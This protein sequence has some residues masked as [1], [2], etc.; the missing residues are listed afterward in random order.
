MTTDRR[1]RTVEE[2]VAFFDEWAV[3]YDDEN[4]G[5]LI[6]TAASLVVDHAAPGPYDTVVDLG[7]GTGAVALA[8]AD[9]AGTVV[10]RDVSEGMLARAREKAAERGVENVEF[11]AGSFREPNVDD[12][13]VVVSNFALHHLGGA[14]QCDAI[15]AIAEL[16]PRKLVTGHCMFF[17]DTDPAEPVYSR[18]TIYPSTV[19]RLVDALTDAGFAV[20][21]VEKIHDQVGVLVGERLDQS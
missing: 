19:G 15:G 10:G 8:L 11:G 3:D 14:E 6:R 12:A 5:E 13:D 17:G 18:E 1:R 7:T 21:A 2:F 4:D 20:T 9:D 16:E